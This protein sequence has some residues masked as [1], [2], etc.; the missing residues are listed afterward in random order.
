M[1]KDLL[2]TCTLGYND[3]LIWW[4]TFHLYIWKPDIL[5]LSEFWKKKKKRNRKIEDWKTG[6]RKESERQ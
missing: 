6:G 3:I 4:N 1:I 2:Y 5:D